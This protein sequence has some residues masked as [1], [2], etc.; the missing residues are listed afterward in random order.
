MQLLVSITV[1]DL[2]V[3]FFVITMGLRLGY[4]WSIFILLP[5]L[6]MEKLRLTSG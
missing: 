5:I 6:Q 4:V 3:M 1:P 2:T